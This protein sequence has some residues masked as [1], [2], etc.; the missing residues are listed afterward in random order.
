MD[1]HGCFRADKHTEMTQQDIQ[2]Y[3][4]LNI[5]KLA[6]QTEIQY[7]FP[8]KSHSHEISWAIW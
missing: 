5:F 6:L 8:F 1:G 4:E 7:Y 3:Q 2:A